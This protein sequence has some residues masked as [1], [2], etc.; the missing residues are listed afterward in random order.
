MARSRRRDEITLELPFE[1]PRPPL[2]T[3]GSLNYSAELCA[4]L[5]QMF[6]ESP[7]ADRYEIA[8]K[9]SELTGEKITKAQI[10]A[11]TA[12]SKSAWRFPF[13]FAAAAEAACVSTKLQELFSRKRGS[14]ILIGEES[15]LAELGRIEQMEE[16]LRHQKQAI[17]AHLGRRK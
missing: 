7:C 2:A 3:A 17:K 6:E 4:A 11:W 10:D 8:A 15:L 9:M 14:R 12:K 13:E 5:N 16:E 1:I